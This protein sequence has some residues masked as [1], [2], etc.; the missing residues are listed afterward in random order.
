MCILSICWGCHYNPSEAAQ[1]FSTRELD[2][3]T[4]LLIRET[5]ASLNS[6]ADILREYKD[7]TS[8]QAVKVEAYAFC[9]MHHDFVWLIIHCDI[10][11]K[12][13]LLDSELEAHISILE[14]LIWTVLQKFQKG[15]AADV[16]DPAILNAD[17]EKMML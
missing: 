6:L 11:S 16:L 14:L 3:D 7:N 5:R 17:S 4:S 10:S 2:L 8:F 15:Q 13:I 9:C 12:N 1:L